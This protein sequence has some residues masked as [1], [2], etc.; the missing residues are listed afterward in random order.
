MRSS[1]SVSGQP[2]IGGVGSQY[3]S[4]P[5]ET[6]RIIALVL[7]TGSRVWSLCVRE[8]QP[9]DG[10][11]STPAIDSS[12]HGYI[13]VGNPDVGVLAFEVATGKPLWFTSFHPDAGLVVGARAT[14][15][16]L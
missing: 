6:G 1:P 2:V 11:W 12:G 16:V 5:L 8:C 3:G 10:I 13:G 4:T 15:Y 9:G 7:A 14:P